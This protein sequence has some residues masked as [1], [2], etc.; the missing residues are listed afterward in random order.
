MELIKSK[1]EQ[2]KEAGKELVLKRKL[3]GITSTD[4]CE[5]NG[6]NKGNY[7]T[8]EKGLYNFKSAVEAMRLL[9]NKWRINKIK[10]LKLEI[11]ELEEI[12]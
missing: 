3:M 11:K 6:F 9:F 7:S 2:T 4:F 1:T 12:K 10:E 8:A 5:A